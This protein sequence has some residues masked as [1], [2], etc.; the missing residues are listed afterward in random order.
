M[1]NYSSSY[2]PDFATITAPLREL[3]QNNT[4]FKWTR[5]RRQAHEQLITALT[6]TQSMAYFDTHKDTYI[7][8]DASPVGISAILSQRSPGNEDDK[9][10]CYAS[11]ALTKVEQRYSQTEREALAIVWGRSSIFTCLF[12]VKSSH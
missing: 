7:T 9:V 10:V 5:I 1:A 2:T 6:S 11:R 4:K 12:M 8:V 3:T